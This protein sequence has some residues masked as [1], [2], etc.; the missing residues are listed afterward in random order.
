MLS[1]TLK[2]VLDAIM[3]DH[4]VLGERELSVDRA[5]PIDMA[6]DRSITFCSKHGEQGKRSLISTKA[7]LVI[8]GTEHEDTCS[9]LQGSTY[10]IVN[11][12]RLAFARV[13]RRHFDKKREVGVHD[14]VV[15]GDDV[16]IAP[17]AYIGPF[18][19]FGDHVK[20]GTGSR[21]MGSN[22][23]YDGVRIGQNVTVHAG[24]VIGTD[25]FGY[26]RDPEGDVEKFPQI[27]GVVIGDDVEIGSN[28]CIARGTLLDTTIGRGTKIDNLVHIAHNV[29]I[30]EGCLIIAHVQIAG[31][32][33]IGNRCWLAPSCTITTGVT[34]G[35]D[36][37]VAM[38]GVVV[39]DV[40][41]GS[42]VAGNPARP[43]IRKR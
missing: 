29:R 15:M 40:D 17:D 33:T 4:K 30:G 10:V 8:V 24:A 22:T 34:I 7:G 38:G 16:D 2:D 32:V 31:S 18:C 20:I 21:L 23:V 42:F 36:A 37:M 39:R 25:G 43:T 41:P 11:D 12:P 19:S 3:C 1:L 27:G 13:L 28:T 14:T 26:N 35:D 5:R 6:D 9:E